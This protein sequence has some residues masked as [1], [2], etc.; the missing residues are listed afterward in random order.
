MASK[1]FTHLHL[2][3]QYSLLDGAISFDKLFK[4]CK[5]LDMGAV[6]VTDHGNMFGAVEF[7][8]KALDKG[9]KPIIGMEAYIAPGSRSDRTKTTIADA[10]YHLILLAENNTGY[11]NLL[12]LA[13]AGYTEG[14]YYRPRIDKNILAE[15]NEGLIVTS[16]CLKGEV[17]VLLAGGDEKGASEAAEWYL[18]VF[19]PDRFFIEIQVHENDDPKISEGLINI[20]KKLGLGLVATNDVH[21]LAEDDYEAHNCLCCISTG[22]NSDDPTRMIYPRDVY[23]KSPEQ[24]RSLFPDAGEACDNT[25]AIAERCNVGLDLK[26]R[27]APV[28]KPDDGSTPEELLTRLCYAGA[29]QRYGKLSEEI[30]G[31]LDR[32][33][34]V[35]KSKGFA[36]YFLIVWDFCNYAHKNN[37]PV[38]ARGSAVGTVAGYCLGLCNVDPI[39]YDLL[40]ERFM[41]PERNEMPDIDIDICQQGRAKV[42]EYVRQKYGQVAQIITFGTMKARAVIRDLCRVLGVP[43]AEA[44][45]LAKLVP[46]SLDMTLDKAL[47]TEPQLRKAY[48][49][50]EQT[51]RVIDICKKLEGL[52]RHA[53][54]HAAGVVIAD[55]P[56]TNFIPLYKAP[57]SEDIIT[58]FEG[59]MVERVG[60]LKMDFLGLKT[61]SVLERARQLVKSIHGKDIDLE[62]IAP[63]DPKVFEVFAS[64]GT[65]GI[66]QFESGGMQDL[67][68]KMGPDRIEDLIAANALYR[69]GPMILIPDYIDRKH[70]AKWDLPHPIMKEVLDETYGIM[71]YQEQV[72]RICNGLGDIPLREAYTL[73]KAISKKKAKTIAKERERFVAGCVDKGLSK[74]QAQQIFELIERFAGYGFNKSHSTRYAVIAYQTAYMKAYWPVEY[75]AAL[76]TYEMDNTDKVV[77]YIAECKRMD[78]EV[79]APDINESGVDF[80]PLYREEDGG[81]GRKGVI[82]FGLAAVKG[83]GEKA[84]EQIISARE[85]TGR[86]QSLF[87]FCESV[88][89]RA[90]NK[91]VL[92]AL[93][94]A[95][96]FDRLG[97]NRAQMTAGLEKSVQI[98][99]SL[100]ADKQ[101][102]QMNFFG[103]MAKEQGYCEDAQRLPNVPPWPEPQMLAFEKQVLGFYV[104]SN[105]LSHYA[106][107]VSLFSTANSGQLGDYGQDR[108]IVIGGMVT[109]VRF[110]LTK[111]GRNAGAKMAVF[112]LEDLQG[113]VEVVM[114]PD[115]LKSFGHLLVPD[116]VVF[117]K[118]KLDYR[119][120]K[121][122]VLAA[123]LV[124]IDQVSEKLA[125]KVKI[126]LEARDVTTQKVATIKSICQTHKGKSLL[127]VAIRTERGSVYATA[128]RSLCVNP[129]LEFCRKMR[130]V[131]G[132]E[133]FQLT[134]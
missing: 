95:G 23:L 130:Q 67:L 115:V 101:N 127:Y 56:L 25:L 18:K 60:L 3:S 49:E 79:L 107:T 85:K 113:Q 15:L 31:R 35:I 48:E 34:D 89:L 20:A 58:Q 102:G 116:T 123:E 44:D 90:V 124:A 66:F 61:L 97:G 73:I 110:N 7:Y 51:R 77:E 43:L 1:G 45:R 22:K 17:A 81:R 14:F 104:T 6:A 19:G 5:E 65:K 59:P 21:F 118:G 68:M 10:A 133:N 57:D 134:R 50:S 94:K 62:R 98:G 96:A 38:G 119:R 32:E 24:M 99:A 117:V 53:S 105:P 8:T 120:E 28:F 87:H 86:F 33:L 54:V 46:F 131:V 128:D 109:K 47:D 91:Q 126:R 40:F 64:G 111:T 69:P 52:A 71:V 108:Q 29:E 83:V 41:D 125:G 55:E 63:D 92:E 9:I 13:S 72:M 88:D 70:G 16:A 11:Q 121:P 80:T 39:R 4:R 114:F 103:Q 36:S 30:K 84:V 75:M 76:L 78:I 26:R 132:D 100:Q 129:D 27:H 2:H 42:I 122:N 12:K 93:I 82:R 74:N 112:T 106:E 37:I